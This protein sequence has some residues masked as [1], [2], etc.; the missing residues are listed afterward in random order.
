MYTIK[1][2]YLYIEETCTFF[3]VETAGRVRH[4]DDDVQQNAQKTGIL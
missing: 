1:T 4:K 2:V 3:H